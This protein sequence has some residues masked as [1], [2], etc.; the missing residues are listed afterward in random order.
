MAGD[1]FINILVN[2]P[3]ELSEDQENLV[4]KMKDIQNGF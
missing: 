4:K 3:N 2:L 1:L